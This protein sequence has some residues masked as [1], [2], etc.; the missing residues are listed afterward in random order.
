MSEPRNEDALAQA[1]NNLATVHQRRFGE[2]AEALRE[3]GTELRH[4]GV[5]GPQAAP[6]GLE[7]IAEAIREAAK[8]LD[9]MG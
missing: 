2:I 7:L 6:G 8:S 9:R 4:F 1:I 5:A 3:I